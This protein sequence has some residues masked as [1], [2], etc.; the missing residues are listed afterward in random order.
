M[1]IFKRAPRKFTVELGDPAKINGVETSATAPEAILEEIY[2][3]AELFPVSITI[4]MSPKS[5]H[6]EMNEYGETVEAGSDLPAEED[7]PT[8]TDDGLHLD[9][10]K[11]EQAVEGEAYEDLGK[12]QA[13]SLVPKLNFPG[14]RIPTVKKKSVLL[15]VGAVATLGVVAT[16]GVQFLNGSASANESSWETT[17]PEVVAAQEPFS[18]MFGEKAWGIDPGQADSVSWFAAGVVQTNESKNEIALRSLVNGEILGTYSAAKG[19]SVKDDLKW[20]SDLL[21]EDRLA[22]GIRIGDSFVAITDE[23][24]VTQWKVPRGFEVSARGTIP[25]MSNVASQKDAAKVEYFALNSGQ[26]KPHKLTV[27]PDLVTRS[28]DAEWVIQLD[29]NS[30]T[31]ALTPVDRTGEHQA[32]PVH[33]VAP[34]EKATFV[35]H[36][37]AGHG[38]S[39]ALWNADGKPYLGV[40]SLTGDQP[41]KATS[42]VPAPF[43]PPEAKGW[44][45]SPGSELAIVGPYAFSLETGELEEYSPTSDFTRAYGP[46]A[47]TTD[48]NG[49][50][51]LTL[52]NMQYPEVDRIVGYSEEGMSV[53]RLI[54]GSVAAYK[55]TEGKE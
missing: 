52:N 34:T 24:K 7:L 21:F 45:I 23:G 11:V 54:D 13:R 22:V 31:V 4:E 49:S 32:H 40:H 10:L 2:E 26:D 50:K 47:I 18:D 25:L 44:V 20:V 37:A 12:R 5:R 55:M 39:L 1:G 35:Q 48:D 33:L 6:L 16:I 41:G 28:I 53:V 29:L 42:F 30:S 36:L 43:D 15:G 51:K 3:M 9:E 27:N 46:L 19:V 38:Y 14:F 17:L 8:D